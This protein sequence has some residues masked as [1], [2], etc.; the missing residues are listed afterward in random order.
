MTSVSS[1]ASLSDAGLHWFDRPE[2][3]DLEG[4]QVPGEWWLRS[5]VDPRWNC[6]ECSVA[7]GGFDLL[8]ECTARI[9]ELTRD[10]GPPPDDLQWGYRIRERTLIA[11]S[12]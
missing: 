4:I 7:V 2:A 5:V 10:F 6:A 11:S 9:E 8:P 1:T 3:E 12:R